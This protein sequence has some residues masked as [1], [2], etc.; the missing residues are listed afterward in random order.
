MLVEREPSEQL[1]STA[2][3]C[4]PEMRLDHDHD[5]VWQRSTLHR[6]CT[7]RCHGTLGLHDVSKIR[8]K[9]LN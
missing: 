1:C 2:S 5:H 9:A 8:S 7:C 4:S 3:R 6:P